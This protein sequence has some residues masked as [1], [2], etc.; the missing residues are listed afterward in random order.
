MFLRALLVAAAIAPLS[1]C[2]EPARGRPP[3]PG[4]TGLGLRG[5][6]PD[7]LLPGTVLIVDGESFVDAPWGS[8]ALHLVGDVEGGTLEGALDLSLPLTYVDAR[9]LELALDGDAFA[10]L[11]GDGSEFEGT[12]R[13]EVRSAVD[14][15]LYRTTTLPVAFAL[16]ASLAPR[17]DTLPTSGVIFPNEPLAVFGSGLL[18]RGEGESLAVLEGCFTPE[19]E[20]DCVPVAETEVPIVPADPFD[21]ER[22]VFA[23]APEIAGIAPG[24]FDGTVVLRNR[25]VAGEVLDS[26][27]I[28]VAY[29]LERPIV[30]GASTDEASLGQYVTIDGGGF[31]GGDGSTLL[32]FVGTFTSDSSG[33]PI[34]VD[35]LLLPEFV[36][37]HRVR[38]VI[39]ENDALGQLLDVRYD[40]GRFEGT[41][42]PRIAWGD[43]EVVGDPAS[44]AFHLA[45][46][47]QVV[48]VVF[49]PAYVESLRAFG[50]RAVDA[51]VR[52]RVLEVL[53]RDYATIGVDV[54]DEA[55]LDF[56]AYAEVDIG[57]PDPNDLG[58]L[59]YDNTP[60]KDTEN[61]RLYDRIGGVNAVTQQDGYPGF[62][63]VFIESL[64]GYS[65]HP[66][67][68]AEPLTPDPRFDALFDPFRP[69]AGGAPVT[70]ADLAE[71]VPTLGASDECPAGADDR[72]LQIACAV[73]ALGSMVGSTVSHEVGHS[74]GLADPYGPE[75]HNAG[76]AD[77]RLMDAD[78][79]FGERAE[80]DGEGPSVFCDQE[81]AYLRMILPTDAAADPQPRPGCF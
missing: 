10:R 11:G 40:A 71:D 43:S 51:R 17:A 42:T 52:A 3:D 58:L 22:G 16:R 7:L 23:F 14:E 34:E 55:P 60:G 74:L 72:P 73:W 13:V 57:G 21:R 47:R 39:S 30:Y 33:V 45:P 35:E 8:S 29:D 26:P 77:N 6:A 53:R 2:T 79:P 59:G 56:A 24:R 48:H 20:A 15:Q 19:G 54:R 81:Y 18:L 25:H 66:G 62:G 12:L 38:Y 61:Q 69:D 4:L 27:A 78:R 64:F 50:L 75:F 36:D 46:V 37:G 65:E 31:V 5:A 32:D 41:V 28:T 1:G 67:A 70:A 80:L 9:T 63:G 68:L 49:T 76:D 44:F